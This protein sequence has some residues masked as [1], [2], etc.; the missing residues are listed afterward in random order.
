MNTISK[1]E[2]ARHVAQTNATFALEDM[3]PDA[4]DLVIQQRYIDGTASLDDLLQYARAF[5]EA[6]RGK[7]QTSQAGVM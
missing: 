1:A 6:N 7:R 5:A 2:R 3:H 4:D